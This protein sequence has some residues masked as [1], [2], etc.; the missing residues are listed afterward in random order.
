MN[1][2][3]ELKKT[4]HYKLDVEQIMTLDDIKTIFRLMDI[5]AK[6]YDSLSDEDKKYFKVDDEQKD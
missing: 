4:N 2:V 6:D 3:I 1:K 5:Y